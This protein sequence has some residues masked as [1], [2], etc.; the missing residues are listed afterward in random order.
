M[1]HARK[2]NGDSSELGHGSR[3]SRRKYAYELGNWRVLQQPA[4]DPRDGLL[5]LLEAS[6]VGDADEA[7]AV[8]AERGA[9]DGGNARL[10]EESRLQGLGVEPGA[11]DVGE[12]IEGAARPDAAEA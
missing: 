11:G 12:G 4:P 9:G 7:L 3:F 6:S 8:G 1:R 10:L 5:K 2:G